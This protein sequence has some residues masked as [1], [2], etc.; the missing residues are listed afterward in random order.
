MLIEIK[1]FK[2][3]E[4]SGIAKVSQKPYLMRKQSGYAYVL[5]DNGEA[6]PYPEA[7]EINLDKD[8]PPY[9]VGK[10]YLLDSSF[11]VGDFKSLS[12]G[13]LR[14]QSVEAAK[15]AHLLASTGSP[16]MKPA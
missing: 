2:V 10:Y 9:P 6:Q 16:A 14:L 1:S 7:I 3:T 13:K 11:V 4:L 8:Q 12:I 5:D 15:S